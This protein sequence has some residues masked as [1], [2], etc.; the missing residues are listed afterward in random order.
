MVS[1]RCLRGKACP[2]YK[3]YL[4]LLSVL[5]LIIAEVINYFSGVYTNRVGAAV[6]PDLIL[7]YIPPIDL[8][9]LFV[10]GFMFILAVLA[11]YPLFFKPKKLHEVI[12]HVSFLLMVRAIFIC[13]THLKV[14]VGAIMKDFPGWLSA[15]SF[16]NDL[17]FSGH[18]AVPFLGFLLFHDSKIKYFFLVGSIIMGMTVLF[19]HVY[20]SI[21]VFSAF[22]IAY[23]C[24][25]F[26]EW[27]FGK[28]EE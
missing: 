16:Q 14:P 7:D 2:A 4:L 9:F 20:Y 13:F 25:K 1:L 11:I 12:S 15:F 22:F 26:G 27:L 19:M 21:D 8:G 24:Y 28:V 3:I 6:S 23:G 18:T 10:Y 17:F 5:F